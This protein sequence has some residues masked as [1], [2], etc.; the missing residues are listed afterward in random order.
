MMLVLRYLLWLLGRLFFGLRYRVK[1]Q[2]LDE[3]TK[4]LAGKK[5]LLILPNHPG[6]ADPPLVFTILWPRFRP[7]PLAFED[8][9]RAPGLSLLPKLLNAILIPDLYSSASQQARAQAEK[10]LRMVVEAL[11]KGD[12]VILW[13]SGRIQRRG[14]EVLGGARALTDILRAVPEAHL[15]LV[16]TRGVWGSRSSFAYT[17]KAPAIGRELLRFL[18]LL[19]ANLILFMPR[20]TVTITVEAIDRSQLPELEREKVNPWF[21]KWYNA[22]VNPE[23]PTYVPY[24][25]LFRP[26]TYTFPQP[27]EAIEVDLDQIK[28]QT[29][30]E[31]NQMV[32]DELGRPLTEAEQRPETTLDQL[33]LDSLERMDLMLHIEQH[34]G[35]SGGEVPVNLG[36]LWA[37]AQGLAEKGPPKPPPP[38]WFAPLSD[39]DGLHIKGDTIPQAFVERALAHRRDVIAADD[40]AGTVNYERMLVGALLMAKRFRKIAAPNLGLLMPASVAGD[41]ALMGIYLA[42]K[43]PVLLNWTTGP[44]NLAHAAR[45]MKLTHVVTSHAFIDRS[46]VKVEG[47]E[48]IFL[49]ELR[50]NISKLEALA[51]LLWVRF[52]PGQVRHATPS[53]DP[54]QPAVVLFTSGSEKAPKAVP[55]THNNILSNQRAGLEVLGLTRG[56]SILG[57][58]P[59]FHSF[60]MS[61]TTLAPLLTGMRVVHHPDPTDAGGLVRKIR[62]YQPTVVCGTPTFVSYIFDRAKPGDLDSLR[63]IVVGA[64][65]CPLALFERCGKLAPQALLIE[66]YGITEC[67]P[68]VSG[69]WPGKVRPG[70]IGQPLP[71]MEVCIVDLESGQPVPTGEMGMLL[72]SGP[73]VFPGYLGDNPPD[74]FQQRD[75]KR[76]YVTGDLAQMDADGYLTFRGRLK[77]FLKAGGEMISLPALEEPFVQLY[78]PTKD[79]PRV[80]VEGIETEHSRRIVLFTTE[81]LTLKEANAH[82][83]AAGFR[84]VLRLD[85]VR[86]LDK[87]PVLGTGKTD[88]KLLRALITDSVNYN[89]PFPAVAETQAGA[90]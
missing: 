84:G 50:K 45:L 78:P 57:F 67:A 51:M 48:F 72:V 83:Q 52:C 25:F 37:L 82:L 1:V 85:E 42:G 86:R 46:G 31:V 23:P 81:P 9:F 19:L 68:V 70:T 66:G 47:V 10:A 41:I 5:P 24:H 6:M 58:L 3:V 12:N 90:G 69:N 20:R 79:G 43:L 55:L 14:T 53:V 30:A 29:R 11:K 35:F 16:R 26:G 4:N 28:P 44:G 65:K 7:R 2:G 60:G 54:H 87:I 71:N 74:P 13:P 8:N 38:E 36:Q 77:R 27:A 15:V 88:Y 21:E 17:G 33:G 80:A 34:F 18:G 62:A 49:E 63:L 64:E 76:W 22:D 40:I 75:G 89:Q 32:A 73:N 59:P 56:D 39:Q 61:V